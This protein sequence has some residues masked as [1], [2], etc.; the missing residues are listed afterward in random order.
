ME[1][2]GKIISLEGKICVTY[3][4]VAVSAPIYPAARSAWPCACKKLLLIKVFAR[5]GARLANT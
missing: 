3:M 2:P 5:S 1:S 4:K